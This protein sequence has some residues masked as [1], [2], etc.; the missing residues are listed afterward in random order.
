MPIWKH[1]LFTD[2]TEEWVG[3]A[4]VSEREHTGSAGRRLLVAGGDPRVA[5]APRRRVGARGDD[6]VGR[7]TGPSRPQRE[8]DRPVG[9]RLRAVRDG[10]SPRS[11]PGA[12]RPRPAGRPGPQHRHRGPTLA[13]PRVLTDGASERLARMTQRTTAGLVAVLLLGA[14]V[15]WTVFRPMPYVTYEP[16]PDAR[17]PRRDRR[18]GDH[19]GRAATRCTATPASSG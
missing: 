12:G 4:C 2:G 19:P 13:A 3:H 14:L 5:A 15:A 6:G 10:P 8:E 1:Q 7:A 16:G 18:Q 9:G 11:H 17:R